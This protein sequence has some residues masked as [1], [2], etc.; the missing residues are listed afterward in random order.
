MSKTLVEIDDEL[1]ARAMA[2]AG[3]S[4]KKA[5]INRA[6]IEMVRRRGLEEYTELLR[7]GATA[8]LNDPE[9]TRSAQR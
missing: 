1:M 8:D 7:S 2:A 3:E 4:T 5:T 9:V 6:L